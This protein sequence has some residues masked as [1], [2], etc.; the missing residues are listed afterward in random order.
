VSD[1]D[2]PE[3]WARLRELYKG[4]PEILQRTDPALLPESFRVRLDAPEHL[5]QLLRAL[6]PGPPRKVAG[7][8]RCIEGVDAVTDDKAPL[9]AVLV[10]KAWTTTTSPST[11]RCGWASST[12]PSAAAARP[13]S[14]PASFSS[15]STP[16]G[17]SA[18]PT[19]AGSVRVR[20]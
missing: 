8:L 15:W 2:L 20:P 13:A 10:P 9:K 14:A 7:H 11:G 5:K 1:Y 12:G 16:G 18:Q 4:K 3:A 6:C 17:A 19:G